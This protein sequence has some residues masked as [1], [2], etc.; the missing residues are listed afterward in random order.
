MQDYQKERSAGTDSGS[1]GV[2]NGQSQELGGR[3]PQDSHG[4]F[5]QC[6]HQYEK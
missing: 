5:E 1:E 3:S 6:L 4:L 2:S